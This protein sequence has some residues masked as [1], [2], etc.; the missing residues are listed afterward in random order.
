MRGRAV[1]HAAGIT[2]KHA[3]TVTLSRA[4]ARME[5]TR[6][7]ISANLHHFG[8]NEAGSRSEGV[9]PLAL[10]TIRKDA[11]AADTYDSTKVIT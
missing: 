2:G 3:L 6:N 5:S 4:R 10:I 7:L 8:I 9:P 1:I 11:T